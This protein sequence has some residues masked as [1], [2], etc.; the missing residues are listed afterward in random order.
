MFDQILTDTGL[1]RDKLNE[2]CKER[3]YNRLEDLLLTPTMLDVEHWL[4]EYAKYARGWAKK[5]YR[6]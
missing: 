1:T 4:C 2:L 5:K 6:R 3:G